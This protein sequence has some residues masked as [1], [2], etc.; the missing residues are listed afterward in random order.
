MRMSGQTADAPELVKL[1]GGQQ[2]EAEQDGIERWSIVPLRRKENVACVGALLE[3]AQL[4]EEQPAHDLQ[5]AETRAD[6]SG[7]RT[8][9]H[10]ERVDAR[11]RRKRG[12]LQHWIGVRPHHARKLRR[13]YETKL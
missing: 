9:N 1:I 7:P 12:G 4:I 11:Q 2:P 6:V 5:R 13:R 3:V 8:G 10:V